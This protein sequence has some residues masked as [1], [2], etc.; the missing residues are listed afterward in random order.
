MQQLVSLIILGLCLKCTGDTF[1]YIHTIIFIMLIDLSPDSPYKTE[2]IYAE[3]YGK[4][5]LCIRHGQLWT[6]NYTSGR[7]AFTLHSQQYGG[8]CYEVNR[9]GLL[10]YTHSYSLCIYTYMCMYIQPCTL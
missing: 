8:G 7:T 9:G 4:N 1:L 3:T 6:K 10:I 2:D 5:S